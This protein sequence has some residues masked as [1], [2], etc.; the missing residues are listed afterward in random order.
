MLGSNVNLIVAG[1]V[2]ST[3]SLGASGPCVPRMLAI[4]R[5]RVGVAVLLS[6]DLVTWLA[7]ELSSSN[8]RLRSSLDTTTAELRASRPTV[9][10]RNNA[11]D[12]AFLGAASTVFKVLSSAVCATMLASSYD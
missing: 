4:N 5:A 9:P 6:R 7:T 1:L 3:T 2:A 10:S 12:G 11:I 8:Y